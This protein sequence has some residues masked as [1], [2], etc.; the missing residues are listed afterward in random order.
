[1]YRSIGFQNQDKTLEVIKELMDNEYSEIRN[2][3][4]IIGQ[5]YYNY[6]LYK[7]ALENYNVLMSFISLCEKESEKSKKIDSKVESN[8]IINV[9][10]HILN[11]LSAF[12][13]FLDHHETR[14]KRSFGKKSD[15]VSEFKQATSKLFDDNLSYR[16][17]SKFRNYCQHC[18]IPVSTLK[19][20]L[21]TDKNLQNY[22]ELIFE[23]DREHLLTDFD[24]WG[25]IVTKDI[26]GLPQKICLW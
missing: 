19:K 8:Q 2:S 7:I 12:R 24:G 15:Q 4:H 11:F 26:Q 13:T 25:A 20:T 1:M 17:I 6:L 9:N 21:K 23:L 22:T 3:L 14:L 5:H 18:G 10:R 16:F